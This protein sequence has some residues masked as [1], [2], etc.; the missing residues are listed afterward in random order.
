MKNGDA[1]IRPRYP[2]SLAIPAKKHFIEMQQVARSVKA[3]IT[4]VNELAVGGTFIISGSSEY[5]QE[6]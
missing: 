2:W 1:V 5:G 3:E 6:E 4:G